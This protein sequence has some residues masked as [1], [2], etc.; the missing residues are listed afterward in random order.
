MLFNLIRF[1][2][3]CN[4]YIQKTKNSKR[5]IFHT[6][7][8]TPEVFL[9]VLLNVG[10]LFLCC[11][12]GAAGE[13]K[14]ER[15]PEMEEAGGRWAVP[16]ARSLTAC[17]WALCPASSTTRD[18]EGPEANYPELGSTAGDGKPLEVLDCG[19]PEARSPAAPPPPHQAWSH[20]PQK[21]HASN[22]E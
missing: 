7:F 14:R 5:K 18:R 16:G 17:R 3:N 1:E 20:L 12:Y 2:S 13:P 15:G 4:L 19:F 9:S 22:D 10:D 8:H 11:C 6:D 21:G